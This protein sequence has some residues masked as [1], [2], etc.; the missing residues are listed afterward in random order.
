[1]TS[2]SPTPVPTDP[3][4]TDHADLR[5]V[6]LPLDPN[7]ASGM[8]LV[9]D[10]VLLERLGWSIGFWVC[11]DDGPVEECVALIGHPADS[12]NPND[13]EIRRVHGAVQNH[14]GATEDCES[15]AVW[16][17]WVYVFGSQFGSKAGPLERKRQFVARFREGDVEPGE[18]TIDVA[19]QLWAAD[20]FL[21]RLINDALRRRDVDLLP[22]GPKTRKRFVTKAR[23]KGVKKQRDWVHRIRHDDVM[24]NLE[25]AAF[26]GDGSL[27][28]GLRQPVT[29]DGHPIIVALDGIRQVFTDGPEDLSVRAVWVVDNLGDRAAHVGIRDISAWGSELDILVGNVE[30]VD[31]GSVFLEEHPEGGRAVSTHWH[32]DL[33]G[34]RNGGTVRAEFVRGFGELKRVEGCAAAPNGEWFYVSDEDN[35]VQT[36]FTMEDWHLDDAEQPGGD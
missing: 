23:K 28:L 9:T 22:L 17:G 34:H 21:H 29:G 32:V 31:E 6:E 27:V 24:I 11:L 20:F 1:M 19:M 33:A 7:E 30:A 3:Q 35:H 2:T 26:M 12:R 15:I 4:Y 16:D 14:Q 10:D 25:G 36:R 13:W 8:A 5:N 18:E